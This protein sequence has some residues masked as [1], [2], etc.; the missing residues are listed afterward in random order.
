MNTAKKGDMVSVEY[1]G[2]LEDWKEFDSN[3]GK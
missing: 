1:T 3:K 2:T